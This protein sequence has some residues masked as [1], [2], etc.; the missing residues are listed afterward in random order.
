MSRLLKKILG[1]DRLTKSVGEL[2]KACDGFTRTQQEVSSLQVK[3]EILAR[4][5]ESLKI[6]CGRIAAQQA[7]S[8][9]ASSAF[10]EAEFQVFS[11]WGEDGII[12]FLL[13][14]VPMANEVFV[15]F[16][17]QD[18][19]ESNTRFLLMNNLWSGLIMDGSEDWMAAVRR[20]NLSWRHTLHAK[21]AWVTA[22]NV[23][24]LITSAGIGGDIGILSVDIDGV[25]Y[26]VWK[27]INVVQP[28]IIIVEY[29][30]LF[31][32][33][34][35]VTPPYKPDF[36]RGKAHHSH[37]FY[38]ISLA[39]VEQLGAE[40]GYTLV[41]TNSAG[42]NAFLVRNELAGVFPKRSV[43]ELYTAARFREARGTDGHLVFPSFAEA[44]AMI[45]DCTVHDLSM[46]AER[47]LRGISGWK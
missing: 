45:A 23:N 8:L 15:E 42:N 37:L 14:H 11:Q 5:I 34:I 32:P 40:K 27:A 30:S 33:E 47:P 4:D 17:V 26:W 7:R 13:A 31:G 6:L 39:A 24:E 9:P 21:A 36:E 28:R 3:G 22:E 38:G 18:Y 44:Q 20:S 29:N 19:S 16:G 25:D 12:Q 43:S 1:T 46:G 10:K 2:E 35:K 41:G